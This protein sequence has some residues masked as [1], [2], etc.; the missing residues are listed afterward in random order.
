[1]NVLCF[2]DWGCSTT[3]FSFQKE[4]RVYSCTPLCPERQERQGKYFAFFYASLALFFLSSV[5]IEHLAPINLC[6]YISQCVCC[7]YFHSQPLEKKKIHVLKVSDHNLQRHPWLANT[8][9]KMASHKLLSDVC[10]NLSAFLLPVS[11]TTAWHAWCLP[12]KGGGDKPCLFHCA[13]MPSLLF[14][15]ILF[16]ANRASHNKMQC[17]LPQFSKPP[18]LTLQRFSFLFFFMTTPKHN[19]LFRKR[20][21]FNTWTRICLWSFVMLLKR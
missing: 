13:K 19:P 3:F 12:K 7:N 17:L 9:Q 14:T 10:N 6:G 18:F 4:W 20:I 8:S 21:S 5:W 15:A 11:M 1:M 2:I 16:Q